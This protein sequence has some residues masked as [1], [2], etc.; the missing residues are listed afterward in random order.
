MEQ[1]PIR[2]GKKRLLVINGALIAR[3]VTKRVMSCHHQW[4][5]CLLHWIMQS[6]IHLSCTRFVNSR[7]DLH[8]TL[9]VITGALISMT[10]T[11][12]AMIFHHRWYLWLLHWM[13]HSLIHL[14]CFQ[15]V[16][17]HPSL[18]ITQG[19][20]CKLLQYLVRIH[21]IRQIPFHRRPPRTEVAIF[22]DSWC[23]C[24]SWHC[25]NYN[26]MP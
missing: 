14:I 10:V 8:R 6:S 7:P 24:L 23:M 19:M 22:M 9:F 20:S 3:T 1:G 18:H 11:K 16:N 2:V 26:S 13:I 4:Y 15:F 12:R 17:S 21:L 5:M 25:H